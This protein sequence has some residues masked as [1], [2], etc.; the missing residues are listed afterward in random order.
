MGWKKIK[1]KKDG[2]NTIE[3]RCWSKAA[4]STEKTMQDNSCIKIT[5]QDGVKLYSVSIKT[6]KKLD[7]DAGAGIDILSLG[8]LEG[9]MAD[10]R[11]CEF[12]CKPAFGTDL[13]EIP[14]ETQGLIYRK[15]D[16][17]WG[18]IIPV[19]DKE[20][21]C[22]LC[23]NPDGGATARIFSWY[24]ELTDCETLAFVQ[25][26]GN[27]PF[28]L[29]KDC[30]AVAMKA[31]GQDLPT[32]EGRPYPE[33]LEYLGWCS[34]DAMQMRV[35]EKD[36]L[37]K[38]QEFKDKGIPV[39]WAIIDDMW[40]EVHEFYNNPYTAE[41]A[42]PTKKFPMMH[43]STLFSF[44]AD[45][46]RFPNGLKGCIKKIND[47]GI[48]V[49]MWHPTTGYWKGINPD[50]PIYAELKDSLFFASNDRY[51]HGYTEEDAYKF[52]KAFHDFLKDCGTEFVKID[53]QTMI[54]RFYKGE[55]P[56]GQIARDVHRAIERS[57]DEHWGATTMI[58]CMGMGSEDMFN[59]PM[60]SVSRCS[61]DFQPENREW[62]IMHLLMCS[63][64]CLIQGQIF[65]GDWDMWWTDDGQAFKNSV[66]R[67][68]SGGPI[69]ISDKMERS[70]A[71]VLLPLVL[72]DGR[73]LR[74]D[75]PATPA[76]DCLV[77]NPEADKKIFKVQNVCGN[78]GV[79]ATFNL[80]SEEAA[81]S[82]TVSPAD[83]YGLEGEEFAVYEHFSGELKMM[84][85]NDKFD[86]TLND[87]D[88]IRLYVIVPVVDGFAPIGLLDKFISPKTI[89]SVNGESVELY[90]GGRYGYVKDGKLYVEER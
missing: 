48:K 11:R 15:K 75:R 83:V 38:C 71:E 50:G 24:G 69:Y 52:Y 84:G 26:E 72:S 79:L 7:M 82:G 21:K 5:E 2:D 81:V 27:D 74:C 23:G 78:A 19:V 76:A 36:L 53:N 65:W 1:T 90:E 6:D 28:A 62:F 66:L 41:D 54:R 3:L 10:F 88:D 30:F 59:R 47:Y 68:M 56:V 13:K 18:A 87:H 25:K 14:D 16:G 35:N 45:P 60:S 86:L 70:R 40:G 67:A 20:Y 58:N 73:I 44:E 9:L 29:L 55:A 42:E 57:V 4:D 64:N 31:L 22:V 89:K 80:D 77:S 39:R 8:E 85:K 37:T 32:I 33:I 63:Y 43:A 49:G 17:T 34:W 46:P 12:W 61:G 51:I